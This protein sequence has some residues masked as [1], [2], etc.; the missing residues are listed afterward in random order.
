MS[1]HHQWEEDLSTT[2]SE[3]QWQLAL[4]SVY[5]VTQCLTLWELTQ[6]ISLRW[7]LT[8]AKMASFSPHTPNTCLR[9]KSHKGD[10]FH[11][12]WSC[13]AIQKYWIDTFNLLTNIT[14]IPIPPTPALA[15]LNLNIEN[16]P[17]PLRYT[18]THVL[19]ASRL[20]LTR[21][22]KS[23]TSPTITQTIDL[24]SLH[25]SYETMMAASNGRATKNA[26]H[27]LPWTNWSNAAFPT[28]TLKIT[29]TPS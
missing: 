1:P 13:S 14:K 10:I 18:T 24:V 12:F 25:Y 6:K 27:W 23:D 2:F 17:G 7:Y 9:F 28:Q 15:L 8:P 3:A 22:W 5:K 26:Q 29:H 16:I 11:I 20:N 19:L 21:H 4:K